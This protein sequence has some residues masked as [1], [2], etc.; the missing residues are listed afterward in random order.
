[1]NRAIVCLAVATILSIAGAANAQTSSTAPADSVEAIEEVSTPP[2]SKAPTQPRIYWG[3]AVG[4]SFWND[5]TRIALEPLV[6][7]KLTPKFSVGG[8][9]RYEYIK[10][11]RGSIDYSSHNYGASV[12]SRY[13]VVPPLYGHAELVYMSYD[14]PLGREWVPFLLLGGGYAKPMGK[15]AWAYVEVLFDV[16]QDKNSPYDDWDPLISVGIGVGF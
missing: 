4:F 15:R 9:V 16:I 2:A 5:Y 11:R 13:R 10:D 1:M 3:G 7:Y 12:F 8:K 6:G 14:Y